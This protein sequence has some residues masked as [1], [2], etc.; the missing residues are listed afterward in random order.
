MTPT[1]IVSLCT[2]VGNELNNCCDD[3]EYAKLLRLMAEAR[4]EREKYESDIAWLDNL[5]RLI[6]ESVAYL[7]V[8]H[9]K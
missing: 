5:K 2:D 9:D 1:D 3:L 6:D 8:Q 4:V 7:G